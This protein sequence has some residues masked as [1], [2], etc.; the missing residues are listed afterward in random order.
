MK[1]LKKGE[2]CCERCVSTT[3]SS[4]E[5]YNEVSSVWM[6]KLKEQ[7][8]D[9]GKVYESVSTNKIDPDHFT[10][11]L[12]LD[13]VERARWRYRVQRQL[14]HNQVKN[15]HH[16]LS[17]MMVLALRS[18]NVGLFV[19]LCVVCPKNFGSMFVS[20]ASPTLF[21]FSLMVSVAAT[22]FGDNTC[23][24]VIHK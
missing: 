23:Q 20:A 2:Q 21:A 24:L 6:V 1:T 7:C 8:V 22:N 3:T 9:D 16:C 12:V 13:T 5:N 15:T 10:K 19:I 14:H 4:Q 17:R 18:V 11:D